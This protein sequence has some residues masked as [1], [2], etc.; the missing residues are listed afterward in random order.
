M[1]EYNQWKPDS[2]IQYSFFYDQNNIYIPFYHDNRVTLTFDD[3]DLVLDL[4]SRYPFQGQ[5]QLVVVDSTL[6]TE[7]QF[8][9]FMPEWV[10]ARTL[11]VFQAGQE[12]KF[13]LNDSFLSFFVTHR[14][15]DHFSIRFD[16]RFYRK[17]P[18]HP[19]IL[20]HYFRYFHGPLLLGCA[21][22]AEIIL[23]KNPKFNRINAGTYQSENG[24]HLQPLNIL[25][26]RDID[27]QK[28]RS[29][30]FVFRNG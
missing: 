28:K 26:Y 16:N 6:K 8:H 25:E 10:D 27:D 12:I 9:F 24:I 15:N 14:S 5:I 18:H 7:K 4:S 21:N 3:G 11:N 13:S 23:S 1:C 19:E 30:Q 22:D 17:A 20:P 29:F 2:A